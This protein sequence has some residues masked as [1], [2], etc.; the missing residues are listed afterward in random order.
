M[1]INSYVY[2][3]FTPLLSDKVRPCHC[4]SAPLNAACC[5]RAPV[6]FTFLLTCHQLGIE[7]NLLMQRKMV[8]RVPSTSCDQFGDEHLYLIITLMLLLP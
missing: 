2:C 1:G 7:I 5:G 8:S 4:C 3:V 6:H